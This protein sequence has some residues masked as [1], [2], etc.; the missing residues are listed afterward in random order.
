MVYIGVIVTLT[1]FMVGIA[2]T[3]GR[4]TVRLENVEKEIAALATELQRFRDSLE[5]LKDLTRATIGGRRRED[6]AGHNGSV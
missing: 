4:M 5:E 2:F 1:L 6:G 3:S